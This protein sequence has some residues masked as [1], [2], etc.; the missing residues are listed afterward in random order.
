[1]RKV[2]IKPHKNVKL[3]QEVLDIQDRIK[4]TPIEKML[5]LVKD[6]GFSKAMVRDE[7]GYLIS[8]IAFSLDNRVFVGVTPNP[9]DMYFGTAF[10]FLE[11]SKKILE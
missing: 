11:H 9:I 4:E 8:G 5:E 10:T 7:F 1:M 6:K 2:I 3:P